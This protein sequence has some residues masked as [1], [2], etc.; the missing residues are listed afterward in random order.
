MRVWRQERAAGRLARAA[1]G[2]RR[3]PVGPSALFS[4]ARGAGPGDTGALAVFRPLAPRFGLQTGSLQRRALSFRSKFPTADEATTFA[5]VDELEGDA[6]SP[7]LVC[8][9]CNSPLTRT[10]DLVFIKW[11]AW[12][13]G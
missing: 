8:G 13:V 9:K 7:K 4:S 6:A 11:C 5:A 3:R 1:A 10:R 2:T 12:A